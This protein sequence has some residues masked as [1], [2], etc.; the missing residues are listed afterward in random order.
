MAAAKGVKMLS[1]RR[2][3]PSLEDI[4]MKEVSRKE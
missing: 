3:E 4:F 2:L 1:I